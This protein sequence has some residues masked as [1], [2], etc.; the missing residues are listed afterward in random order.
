MKMITRVST[1]FQQNLQLYKGN[2][3]LF[4]NSLF[5]FWDRFLFFNLKSLR[6]V[7]FLKENYTDTENKRNNFSYVW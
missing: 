3:S 6:C 1:K 4:T 7:F 5:A 2:G